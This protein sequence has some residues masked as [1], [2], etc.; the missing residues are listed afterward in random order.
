M[1]L[2]WPL[3]EIE[4]KNKILTSLAKVKSLSPKSNTTDCMHDSE[5]NH[6]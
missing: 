4:K 3:K 6:S 1:C 5:P 2:I